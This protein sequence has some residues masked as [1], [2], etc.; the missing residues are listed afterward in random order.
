MQPD[1][2]L[3][4]SAVVLGLATAHISRMT[5][6]RIP[7]LPEP[8][9]LPPRLGDA[10]AKYGW[11]VRHIPRLNDVLAE[12]DRS[13]P[14]K[15]EQSPGLP[16]GMVVI[17]IEKQPPREIALILGDIVHSLRASLDYATCA[18]LELVDPHADLRKV[19]FPFGR[20]GCRLNSAE[21]SAIR[22]LPNVAIQHVE[23]ARRLGIPYM[24]VLARLSNQDK[25]RLIMPVLL[26]RMPMKVEV[27]AE[28]NT[29]DIVPDVEMEAVWTTPI[30]DGDVV[31]MGSMFALRPGF[32]I[33]DDP[34]P[35][36]LYVLAHMLEVTRRALI[37]MINAAGSIMGVD[38]DAR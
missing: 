35:Y 19:Q 17:R 20:P 7:F 25:H 8:S 34:V 11:A 27:D 28:R 36:S 1:L 22:Q 24:D 4:G 2:P 14:W 12:F 10:V 23:E 26:R 21:R 38:A 13:D 32:Q 30:Q 31:E 5:D 37:C 3:L 18:L 6:V 15:P 16:Q 33:E 9:W 29:A